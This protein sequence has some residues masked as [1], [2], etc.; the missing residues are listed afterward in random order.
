MWSIKKYVGWGCKIY[1]IYGIFCQ[2]LV[3][4]GLIIE[5]FKIHDFPEAVQLLLKNVWNC[6]EI[7]DKLFNIYILIQ[8]ESSIM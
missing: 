2:F 7:H 4:N 5:N 1:S 3:I 6:W 8:P